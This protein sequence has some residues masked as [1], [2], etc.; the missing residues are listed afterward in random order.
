MAFMSLPINPLG[1][2]PKGWFNS[3]VYFPY[4]EY[5]YKTWL[6]KGI[7]PRYI[8]RFPICYHRA[9]TL[10][11]IEYQMLLDRVYFVINRFNLF[12][13]QVKVVFVLWLLFRFGKW[14]GRLEQFL[15]ILLNI[16][17]LLFPEELIIDI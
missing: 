3:L 11:Y 9:R 7:E 13:H 2:G 6:H 16:S 4:I 1:L 17:L 12:I 10:I 15:L 14:I 8:I 5:L